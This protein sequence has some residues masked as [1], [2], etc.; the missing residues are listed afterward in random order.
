MPIAQP[1]AIE[2]REPVWLSVMAVAGLMALSAAVKLPLPFSPVPVTLQTFAALVIA[3]LVGP[4]RATAGIAAYTALG[5]VGAPLFAVAGGATAGY[6]AA[7]IAVPYVVTRFRRPLVGMVA[8]MACIYALGA[9]WLV[10][11]LGMTPAQALALGIV[12]FLPG[13]ALKLTAAYGVARRLPRH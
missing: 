4:H 2:R 11:A 13:D 1:A 12:P 8:A 6:L 9:G 10:A 5:M 7:F 3:Y